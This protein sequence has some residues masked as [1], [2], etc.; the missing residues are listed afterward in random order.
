[1]VS[2]GRL[3]EQLSPMGVLWKAVF[4]RTL[5]MQSRKQRE[6]LLPRAGKIEPGHRL[7]STV[8]VS[9]LTCTNFIPTP[10][11]KKISVWKHPLVYTY[12]L[13]IRLRLGK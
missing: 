4:V 11:L 5:V 3:K 12:L 7:T 2:P 10:A 9:T 6:T 8:G 13:T 1:M